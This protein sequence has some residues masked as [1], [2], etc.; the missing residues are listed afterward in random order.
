MRKASPGD[1]V[2]EFSRMIV[3]IDSLIEPR[4]TGT[5]GALATRSPIGENSAQEKSR[6]SL[7]L[8]DEAVF[9]STVP[10]CSATFINK[11]LK[12]SRI[13]GSTS[14]PIALTLCN[15]STRSRTRSLLALITACQPGSTTIVEVDSIITAGPLTSSFVAIESRYKNGVFCN[16]PAITTSS[17]AD[18][19]V[20]LAP[21]LFRSAPLSSFAQDT[22][23]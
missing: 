20:V 21:S 2:A 10:I 22:S 11:L 16:S 7:I 15:I 14:V 19:S 17:V 18:T 8:T 6:R 13:T 5:W 3:L 1:M 12:I 9:S 4:C 23:I